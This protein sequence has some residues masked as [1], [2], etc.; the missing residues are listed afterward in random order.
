[1]QS[2]ENASFQAETRGSNLTCLRERFNAWRR[3]GFKSLGSVDW[4]LTVLKVAKPRSNTKTLL[5]LLA[6][7]SMSKHRCRRW[8][9]FRW[10]LASVALGSVAI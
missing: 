1:M 9:L 7:A 6:G 3:F 2:S 8:E 4:S 5:E 10:Q